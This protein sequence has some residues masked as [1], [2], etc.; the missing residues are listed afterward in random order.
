LQRHGVGPDSA[1]TLLITACGNP[2]RLIS[3]VLFTALWRLP[4]AETWAATNLRLAEP[5]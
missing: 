1:A 4:V 2:D 5:P 3:E